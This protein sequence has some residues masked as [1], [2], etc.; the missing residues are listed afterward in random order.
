MRAKFG[1]VTYHHHNLGCFWDVTAG[2]TKMVAFLWNRHFPGL[3]V[4][5]EPQIEWV[6]AQSLAQLEV[7]AD[8]G[9][10]KN[11]LRLCGCF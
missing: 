6:G 3:G 11:G 1:T 9:K 4:E 7:T 2:L 5:L 8:A 10:L